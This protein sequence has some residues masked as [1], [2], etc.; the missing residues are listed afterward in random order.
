[1]IMMV[2]MMM[3]MMMMTMM[4]IIIINGRGAVG[5]EKFVLGWPLVEH[6]SNIDQR[7]DQWD[8]IDRSQACYSMAQFL[9]KEPPPPPKLI[10]VRFGSNVA[11]KLSVTQTL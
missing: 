10:L 5:N 1:M 7:T 9:G 11:S 8:D 4:I 6:D 2:M 3:V